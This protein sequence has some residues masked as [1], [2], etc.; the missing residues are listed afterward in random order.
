MANGNSIGP[1]KIVRFVPAMAL[2]QPKIAAKIMVMKDAMVTWKVENKILPRSARA[3]YKDG[4]IVSEWFIGATDPSL[5]DTG[6][7]VFLKK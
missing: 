7:F 6:G 4:K 5:A 2:P 1:A 3:K